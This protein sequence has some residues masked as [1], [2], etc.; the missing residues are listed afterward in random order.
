MAVL[1]FIVNK[2]VWN[3]LGDEGQRALEVWYQAAYDAM[4]RE[5]IWKTKKSSTRSAKAVR[6]RSSIGPS[7]SV[8][9]SAKS[10]LAPGRFRQEVAP[11]QGSFGRAFGYMRSTGLLK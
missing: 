3:K 9:N 7:P 10:R 4:R 6:S 11:R 2:K 5:A 1:Q 8:P